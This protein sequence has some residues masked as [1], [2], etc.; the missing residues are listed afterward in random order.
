MH[1]RAKLCC[2]LSLTSLEQEQLTKA[3]PFYDDCFK[4]FFFQ[5]FRYILTILFLLVS[6]CF[7]LVLNQKKSP[8]MWATIDIAFLHPLDSKVY[9]RICLF[10]NLP[11]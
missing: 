11:I 5:I 10:H 1:L 8:L 7:C 6:A 3:I 2:W 9:E 4:R